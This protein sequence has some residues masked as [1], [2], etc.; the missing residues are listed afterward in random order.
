MVVSSSSVR[1]LSDLDDTSDPFLDLPELDLGMVID[2]CL[3][4]VVRS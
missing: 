3:W 4:I 2:A 1:L